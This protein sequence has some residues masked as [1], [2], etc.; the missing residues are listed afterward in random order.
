MNGQTRTKKAQNLDPSFTT[1]CAGNRT[2][3]VAKTF[4]KRVKGTKSINFYRF[5]LP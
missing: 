4:F 2:G 3:G 1:L 5:A